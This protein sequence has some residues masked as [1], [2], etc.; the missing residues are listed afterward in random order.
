MFAPTMTLSL[1]ALMCWAELGFICTGYWELTALIAHCRCAA[2]D[3]SLANLT[4]AAVTVPLS[5][6]IRFRTQVPPAPPL[7]AGSAARCMPGALDTAARNALPYTVVLSLHPQL[8]A[9]LIAR[10]PK[11]L[12]PLVGIHRGLLLPAPTSLLPQTAAFLALTGC[13]CAQ[14]G[15]TDGRFWTLQCPLTCRAGAAL[16][17]DGYCRGCFACFPQPATVFSIC[18]TCHSPGIGSTTPE[19]HCCCGRCVVALICCNS[20][21]RWT[22]Q[23]V[24]SPTICNVL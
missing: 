19:Q 8:C 15:W 14:L 1:I 16:L 9:L 22:I 18:Q 11:W 6:A 17:A 12:L 3:C 13:A 5:D 10:C 7:S 24:K 2:A 21:A 4:V 23:A 20:A